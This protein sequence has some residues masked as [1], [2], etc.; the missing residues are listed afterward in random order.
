[1]TIEEQSQ[2]VLPLR[3]LF[4]AEEGLFE[5]EI[6]DA[7]A[8]DAGSLRVDG[9]SILS[10]LFS[11]SPVIGEISKSGELRNKF[12]LAGLESDARVIIFNF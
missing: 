2:L 1:M 11:L 3:S 10:I 8:H 9:E 7:C 4:E 5:D 6:I 12:N